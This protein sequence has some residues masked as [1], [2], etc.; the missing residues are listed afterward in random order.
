MD[1]HTS[2]TRWLLTASLAVSA[3]ASSQAH[4]GSPVAEKNPSP[5]PSAVDWKTDTISPVANPMFAE[6]PVIHSELRPIFAYHR[7]DSDFPTGAGNAQLYAIQARFAITSRLAFIATEDGY[8]DIHLK[9]GA[10]LHG[11][12]DLAAGFKYALID[13]VENQFILTPGFT[14]IIPTGSKEVFQGR[15]DGEWNPFISAEKGFG[16][17]HLQTNLGFRLPDN[18]DTQSSQFHFS[19]MADYRVCQWFIPFVAA[20][21]FTVVQSGKH[22]PFDSEGYDVINFGSSN[23]NGT[24]QMTV[25]AGFRSRLTQNIDFGA[26][27]ELAVIDPHGL[28]KDRVTVDMCFR[29]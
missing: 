21:G 28:T 23:A 24:T 5:P 14:F 6:D 7:I 25:G 18:S 29:F 9:N 1:K 22:L 11:W 20:N 26:A 13:D 10:D 3:L 15:G 2:P 8:L 12:M 27:Y 19:L 4:A 16:K 17:F